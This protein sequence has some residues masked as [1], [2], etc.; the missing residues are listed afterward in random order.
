MLPHDKY[1]MLKHII[2]YLF[3]ALFIMFFS[4]IIIP[5][6]PRPRPLPKNRVE[7]YAI[8]LDKT[9]HGIVH[10]VYGGTDPLSLH[11]NAAVRNAKI[12]RKSCEH[13]FSAGVF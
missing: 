2:K 1:V 8:G 6:P 3:V 11:K 13:D 7:C 5:L 10:V 4:T 12:R 9:L